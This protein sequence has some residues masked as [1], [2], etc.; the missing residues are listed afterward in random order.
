MKKVLNMYRL[1]FFIT[2]FLAIVETKSQVL[3]VTP[4][5]SL[6]TQEKVNDHI[7][8]IHL[9]LIGGMGNKSI[10]VA[11]NASRSAAGAA[12]Y[13]I[14]VNSLT[15]NT[16]N[17]YTGRVDIIIRADTFP[18]ST[19]NLYLQF[20][21]NDNNG[22]TQTLNY[23][24]RIQDVNFSTTPRDTTLSRRITYDLFTGGN[25]DFFEALKFKNV[26]GELVINARDIFGKDDRFG[27]YTGLFNFQYFTF[28][29]SNRRRRQEYIRIDQGPYSPGVTKY[30]VN[31]YVDHP[32]ISTNQWGYYFNPLYRL[33]ETYSDVFNYYLALR[34][35]VLR[36]STKTEYFTDTIQRNDTTDRNLGPSPVFQS[37]RSVLL[38]KF[39]DINT[40]GYFGFSLPLWLYAKDRLKF[41]FEPG[42][43]IA[44]YNYTTYQLNEQTRVRERITNSIWPG[45]YLFRFR[46]ID[47]FSGLQITVGGEIRG[48][49]PAYSPQIN[50]YLGLRA[51]L[52]KWFKKE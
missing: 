34:L 37:G 8:S 14:P 2:A 17:N 47:Q 33:N 50:V 18:E 39:T 19:E 35:E 25:F 43:G 28:D 30:I 4:A 12:D 44:S 1:L 13:S 11:A 24:V 3:N 48:F 36:T 9:S 51:D 38:Q 26:G 22:V 49:L 27:F 7:V 46:A 15:L 10:S 29:S 40:N 23:E 31:S 5:N 32:K 6:T 16:A 41:Y 20:T 52:T 42:V 21:F 45:Y